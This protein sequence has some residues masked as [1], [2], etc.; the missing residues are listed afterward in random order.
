VDEVNGAT[1]KP[2]DCQCTGRFMPANKKTYPVV[3]TCGLETSVGPFPQPQVQVQVDQCLSKVNRRLYRHGREYEVKIDVNPQANQ[4][5]TVYALSDSWMNERAF[6]MAY[7]MYL[8]N[9]SDERARLKK[10]QVA[11]W[12][13]F[14]TRTGFEGQYASINPV[15]YDSANFGGRTELTAGEFNLTTVQDSAG[16]SRGFTWSNVP[17]PSLYGILTEYDKAGN[18]QTSPETATGDMPYDDLMA[19]DSAV[20]AQKLQTNGDNPPYD[21]DGV[22]S[23]SPWVKVAELSAATTA[24]K[25]STGFFKAPCGFV[26][27]SAGVNGEELPVMRHLQLTAKAGAYKG[28]HAPSML[29]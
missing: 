19:D 20:M 26:L 13:D 23:S 4:I 24:Q 2:I 25:L 9:S 8:E 12:E 29:E 14:R 17:N 11:R 6:K 22:G 28:V 1:I 21:A 7:A 3:R 18:A 15:L 27:I 16:V 5:Y 10:G